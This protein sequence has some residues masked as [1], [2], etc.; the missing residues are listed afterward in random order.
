MDLFPRTTLD[1][2]RTAFYDSMNMPVI[3]KIGRNTVVNAKRRVDLLMCVF[4]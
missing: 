1:D 2:I 4:L 3:R